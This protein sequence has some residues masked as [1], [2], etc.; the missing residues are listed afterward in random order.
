MYQQATTFLP[1]PP[2]E[3]TYK[4]EYAEPEQV[5]KP[6]PPSS[7]PPSKEARNKPPVHRKLERVCKT[8]AME[9]VGRTGDEKLA[10]L[11]DVVEPETKELSEDE[12]YVWRGE[13]SFMVVGILTI[14][15]SK[16]SVLHCVFMSQFQRSGLGFS[17]PD[18]LDPLVLVKNLF[19]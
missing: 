13:N 6:K 14:W 5:T 9:K 12:I 1:G 19:L 11:Y 2:G 8:E 4:G 15:R 18:N 17:N 16:C 3:S 7:D 10:P